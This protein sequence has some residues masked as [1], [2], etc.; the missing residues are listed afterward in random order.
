M[1]EH[2]QQFGHK[3]FQTD[4]DSFIP[5]IHQVKFDEMYEDDNDPEFIPVEKIEEIKLALKMIQLYIAEKYIEP[6]AE[7]VE[8]LHNSIVKGI[9]KNADQWHSDA[10]EAP[11]VF[12][13]LYFNDMTQDNTGAFL[14]KNSHDYLERIVPRCGTLIAVENMQPNFLHRAEQTSNT[15]IVACFRYKVE[16]K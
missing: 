13:L 15:R 14:I 11:T 10:R 7:N 12:F 5:F 8:L 16:W 6:Y 3:V 2:L 1:F 4:L 9:A